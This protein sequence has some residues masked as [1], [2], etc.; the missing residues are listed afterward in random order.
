MGREEMERATKIV[1]PVCREGGN[2]SGRIKLDLP[3][4]SPEERTTIDT[5]T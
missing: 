2:V 1:F 4:L 5:K 3:G